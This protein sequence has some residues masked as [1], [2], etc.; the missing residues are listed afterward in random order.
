[1]EKEII[2]VKELQ[3][4]IHL[5]NSDIPRLKG[6]QK[7]P[8]LGRKVL[9]PLLSYDSGEL[10]FKDLKLFTIYTFIKLAD[11]KLNTDERIEKV[12][13]LIKLNHNSVDDTFRSLV[14]KNN[15]K[16][17]IDLEELYDN[18]SMETCIKV[19]KQLCPLEEE[20]FYS[21]EDILNLSLR[22]NSLEDN[23]FPI[24]EEKLITEDINNYDYSNILDYIYKV[25]SQKDKGY[26]AL[27]HPTGNGKT[28]FL[29]NF[30]LNSI[31]ENFE[32]LKNHKKIIVLT[33]SKVNV[34][35]I[36]RNIEKGLKREK[37]SE[38]MNCV[39]QMKSIM[40]IL[41]DVNFLREILIEL[42]KNLYFYTK[43]PFN[44]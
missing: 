29:E 34:N 26:F 41:S 37:Q 23:S 13:E 39:F 2:K 35:E 5:N 18:L 3:K 12:F 14:V 43:F 40:D 22:K 42:Y 20:A 9:K 33:S 15:N 21:N 16:I 25:Y 24:T 27:Q 4:I 7:L 36:Y 32:N 6:R 11:I 28:Y 19:L 30:L 17:Y 8:H 31:L 38:K 10:N 44:F 1:M